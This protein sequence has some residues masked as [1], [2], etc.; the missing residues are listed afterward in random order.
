MLGYPTTAARIRTPFKPQVHTNEPSVFVQD[1]WR[2]TSWLTVNLGVRYDVFTPFS[3]EANNMANIDL[4]GPVPVVLVAGEN[5]VSRYA[6][7]K[8]DYTD[9]GRAFDRGDVAA[10]HRAAGR[11]WSLV[12]PGQHRCE[13]LLEEPAGD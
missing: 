10:R 2:A 1:D 9:L 5:G 6:G 7:I 12:L 13:L 11:L 8:T 4:S 3:E